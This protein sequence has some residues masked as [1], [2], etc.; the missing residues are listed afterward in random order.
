MVQAI[1]SNG[2]EELSV[3]RVG[4]ELGVCADMLVVFLLYSVSFGEI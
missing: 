1:E 3:W 2:R 4:M